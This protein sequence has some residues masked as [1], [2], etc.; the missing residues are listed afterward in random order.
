MY[1]PS[2]DI[3]FKMKGYK[4]PAER[5]ARVF[6]QSRDSWKANAA[7]K[8]KKLRTLEIKVRDLS[9]SRDYWKKKAQTAMAQLRQLEAEPEARQ[10]RG[11]SISLNPPILS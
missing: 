3:G 6:K 2:K 1:L 7:Q 8:Q 10:K 5:L 9:A 4:M 11:D